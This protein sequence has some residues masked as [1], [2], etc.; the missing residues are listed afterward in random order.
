MRELQSP[1]SLEHNTEENQLQWKKHRNV[2]SQISE[3]PFA[4]HTVR[5]R[6]FHYPP[7]QSE[8][9]CL[10]I[11]VSANRN[12]RQ[13]RPISRQARNLLVQRPKNLSARLRPSKLSNE[14]K[15]YSH[16]SS[17]FFG[18][19]YDFRD[20]NPAEADNRRL[21]DT[22]RPLDMTLKDQNSVRSTGLSRNKTLVPV[23]VFI[24]SQSFAAGYLFAQTRAPIRSLDK[25]TVE[26]LIR[27]WSKCEVIV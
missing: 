8:F 25:N 2:K 13:Y 1:V 16:F 10:F 3:R 18:T 17:D 11:N 4:A 7:Y 22:R 12:F 24:R 14:P 5:R 6:I 21:L 9:S 26:V 15:N 23:P 20:P 27:F 19:L